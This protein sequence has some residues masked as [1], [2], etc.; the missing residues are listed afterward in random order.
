MLVYKYR[1]GSFKRD[2]KSLENNEFWAS[3][4]RQLNDPCE[5]MIAISDYEAQMKNLKLIFPQQSNDLT[6]LNQAFQNL[7]DMKD[8]KLGIL[9]LSKSYHDELLWAHYADSHKGF[10]IEYDLEKLLAKQN[11]KHR[12]FNVQIRFRT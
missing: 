9:S 2:L 1:G 8:N 11:P 5:G 6:L 3:H 7:I 4:T 12:F 10:C